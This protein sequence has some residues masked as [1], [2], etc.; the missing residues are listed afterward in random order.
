MISKYK[1][2][3]SVERKAPS[4]FM[5]RAVISGTNLKEDTHW[6]PVHTFY[7]VCSNLEHA[8]A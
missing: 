3:M 7:Q 6:T 2:A 4:L 5:S 8:L 1:A